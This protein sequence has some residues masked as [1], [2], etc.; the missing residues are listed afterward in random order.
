MNL[1]FRLLPAIILGLGLSLTCPVQ[2][3]S[4]GH[5][6]HR[7][8]D[9]NCSEDDDSEGDDDYDSESDDEDHH[10]WIHRQKE[11]EPGYE[12]EDDPSYEVD[13]DTAWP[14]KRENF[15]EMFR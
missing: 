10:A 15:S 3:D 14:S 9:G 7:D 13:H 5:I 11:I 12:D 1:L 4:H 6:I 2:A 8:H